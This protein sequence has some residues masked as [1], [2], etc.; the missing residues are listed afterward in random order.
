A[1]PGQ[2]TRDKEAQN[3]PAHLFSASIRAKMATGEC[4]HCDHA[5]FVVGSGPF[6]SQSNLSD[7]R[8]SVCSYAYC[9]L[10]CLISI[11]TTLW[12]L[13]DWPTCRPLRH[14]IV[15]GH[16]AWCTGERAPRRS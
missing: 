4:G 1:R 3:K 5:V 10:F 6:N 11:C 9:S 12:P 13:V 2:D 14:F 8:C 15:T 16:I 7:W